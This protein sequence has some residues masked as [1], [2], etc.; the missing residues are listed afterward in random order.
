M[1]GISEWEYRKNW[2]EKILEEIITKKF[3]KLVSDS[4][5]I[6]LISGIK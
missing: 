6:L 1:I 5:N 2:E 4:N 3:P